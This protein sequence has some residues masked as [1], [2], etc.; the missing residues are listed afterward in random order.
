MPAKRIFALRAFFYFGQI[1]AILFTAHIDTLHF[2]CEFST[3]SHFMK[4]TFFISPSDFRAWLQKNHDR[5][6]E[7]WVGFYKYSAGTK[8]ITYAEALDEALCFGWIDAVRKSIDK[9]RWTIRFT[10]RKPTSVWSLVNIKHVKRLTKAGRMKPAGLSAFR[11]RDKERSK[12]YSYEV[13]NAP[14]GA[15]HKKLFKANKKA[16]DYYRATS[17]FVPESREVVDREGQTGCNKNASFEAA[18]RGIG[19]RRE[20]RPV[21]K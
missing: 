10:P 2:G 8:G 16:W 21:S 13:Q 17:T 14:L 9:N 6:E 20:T 5:A 15:V 1:P 4:H 11:R 19:P 18:H 7:M 12:V 3:P